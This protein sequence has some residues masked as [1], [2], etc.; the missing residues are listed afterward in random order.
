MRHTPRIIA[1]FG[2][3][4]I[5]RRPAPLTLEGPEET[6]RIVVIEFPS[7]ERAKAFYESDDYQAIKKKR[8]GAGEGQFIIVEGYDPAE[9]DSAVRESQRAG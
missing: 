4:F 2:G 3:R 8:D 7:T 1:R 5:A 9:W 6:R